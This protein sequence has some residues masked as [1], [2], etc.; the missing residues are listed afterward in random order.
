MPSWT[1]QLNTTQTRAAI[2]NSLLGD[3]RT[4][5]ALALRMTK[6]A[7]QLHHEM[8]HSPNMSEERISEILRGEL[9]NFRGNI[10]KQ[11]SVILSQLNKQSTAPLDQTDLSYLHNMLAALNNPDSYLSQQI[12]A[13]I[14]AITD[15]LN[16]EAAEVEEV[17]KQEDQNQ[18]T[19]T[20]QQNTTEEK[21]D[22]TTT[23]LATLGAVSRAAG[24]AIEAFDAGNL[25][26]ET[27]AINEIYKKATGDTE[28]LGDIKKFMGKEKSEEVGSPFMSALKPRGLLEDEKKK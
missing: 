15:S 13:A 27:N 1:N 8:K 18:T 16:I 19:Q 6:L 23:E 17:I 10:E 26:G 21:E 3:R 12:N 25:P 9:R 20:M 28:D 7:R 11:V 24:D 22:G 4:Q 14:G 5:M 2:R